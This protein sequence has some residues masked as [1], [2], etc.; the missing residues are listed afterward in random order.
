MAFDAFTKGAFAGMLFGLPAGPAGLLVLHA[1]LTKEKRRRWAS[2]VGMAF[3]DGLVAAVSFYGL[4]SLPPVWRDSL[5]VL[6]PIAG[7]LLIAT[8]VGFLFFEKDEK[9]FGGEGSLIMEFL[10]PAGLVFTNPGLWAAYAA[11]LLAL[12]SFSVS[13]GIH[14]GVTGL[15]AFSGVVLVWAILGPWVGRWKNK[16][17]VQEH[18]LTQWADRVTGGLLVVFGVWGLFF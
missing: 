8:G 4:S 14:A 17:V 2:T 9:Q 3:A 13:G 16:A 1:W 18:R 10:W 5:Q 6:R 12:G 11:L 7:A 15:G